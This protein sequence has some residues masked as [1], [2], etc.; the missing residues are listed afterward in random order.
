MSREI[1]AHTMMRP[2]AAQTKP[3]LYADCRLRQ[4]A[5]AIHNLPQV[6]FLLACGRLVTAA[7]GAFPLTPYTSLSV[8][9]IVAFDGV[10]SP[11]LAGLLRVSL[12]V[13]LDSFSRSS[14]MVTLK[15]LLVS[16][17]AKASVPLVAV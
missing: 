14:L 16:P 2:L 10:P 11:A 7:A 4:L 3:L 5:E 17:G 8:M 9:V 1:P 6:G 12:T 13:S 15:V